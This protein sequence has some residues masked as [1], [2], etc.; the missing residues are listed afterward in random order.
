VSGVD[1]SRDVAKLLT[2]ELGPLKPGVLSAEQIIGAIDKPLEHIGHMT[3]LI[4]MDR[5]RQRLPAGA[6]T[7]FESLWAEEKWDE[8]SDIVDAYYPDFDIDEDEIRFQVWNDFLQDLKSRGKSL[9]E[10]CGLP[11][12]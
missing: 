7:R 4:M 3:R 5:I 8:A 9:R 11:P 10:W 1:E 12:A 2:R 6:F